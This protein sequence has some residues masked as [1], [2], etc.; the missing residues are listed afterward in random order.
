[1]QWTQA[2][3]VG[4]LCETAVCSHSDGNGFFAQQQSVLQH[5]HQ[6]PK[7]LQRLMT[8]V[9]PSTIT[10]EC[11]ASKRCLCFGGPST[12]SIPQQSLREYP[13]ALSMM[14][15]Q[16][17]ACVSGL[18]QQTQG[19]DR[20]WIVLVKRIQGPRKPGILPV[21]GLKTTAS[22]NMRAPPPYRS[23]EMRG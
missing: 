3:L 19:R 17:M 18:V 13:A 16:A 12:L 9:P 22:F 14:P 23:F 21:V 15:N 20:F 6:R 4:E 1:T 10:N 5:L 11:S 2:A 8:A 7:A